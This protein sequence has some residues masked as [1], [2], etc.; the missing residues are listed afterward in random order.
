MSN[1]LHALKYVHEQG[2]VHRDLKPENL[3]LGSKDNN[4]DL[5]I[6]DFGLATRIGPDSLLSLRCGSP[7]YVAP[8]L[9]NNEGYG[10]KADV[11]SAGVI[12]YVM[13]T[14]RPAFPGTN[15]GEVLSKNKKCELVFAPKHWDKVSPEGMDLTKRLLEKRPE[16]RLSASEALEHEW[17]A[18]D[19]DF[20][21]LDCARESFPAF[22]S[23]Q[24]QGNLGSPAS[25][26]AAMSL[27]TC[28]P[29]LA[30]RKLGNAT[31]SPF[32]GSTPKGG[33]ATPLM[34]MRI[35]Q[36]NEQLGPAKHLGGVVMNP[37][38][39]I[40]NEEVKSG[41]KSPLTNIR[42]TLLEFHKGE[43]LSRGF[44]SKFRDMEDEGG[45]NPIAEVNEENAE[46]KTEREERK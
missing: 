30:G 27:I 24:K 37:L 31:D 42:K 34:Q 45:I 1:L 22:S 29:V 2:V 46:M 4:F 26:G 13:L 12:L 3:I 5:K 10:Q 11:F 14:G 28:T 19:I 38:R 33:N 21:D 41:K 43:T 18:N 9:L 16:D 6:A 36:K 32:W 35:L 40:T 7:G 44:A 23:D 25:S 39:Q 8:E 20:Q 17:F 15:C